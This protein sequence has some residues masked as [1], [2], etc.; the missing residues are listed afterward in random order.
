MSLGDVLKEDK[1]CDTEI[2]RKIGR[3]RVIPKVKQRDE[4]QKKTFR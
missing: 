2:R 1:K 4:K 3:A